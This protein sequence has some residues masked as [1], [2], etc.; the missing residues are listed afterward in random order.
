MSQPTTSI[1]FTPT[2]PA[3][4]TGARNVTPQSD[5]GT[6]LQNISFYVTD[7]VGD[8]GSGGADGLVP[9]PP[10][11]SAAAGKFLKADGTFAIPPGSGSGLIGIAGISMD[12]TSTGL[13][14]FLQIPYAGTITGWAVF[15]DVSGS[16]IVDLWFL[17]GSAPPT[18]PS[19]PTS[20]AKISAT[21]PVALSSAQ[22]AAGGS[23]AISTWTTAISQWGTLAFNLSG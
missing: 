4:P 8:T 17:A 16:A 19:I 14:G 20:A 15:G 23:S 3:A 11:G 5:N 18:A 7:M 12:A 9:A 6:P 1:A 10:A 2:T 21:A 22:S 13:K